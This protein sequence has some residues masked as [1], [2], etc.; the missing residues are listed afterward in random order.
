[1]EK[2]KYRSAITVGMLACSML[3]S[4]GLLIGCGPGNVSNPPKTETVATETVATPPVRPACTHPT[5]WAWSHHTYPNGT[6]QNYRSPSP[7][8]GPLA[9]TPIAQPCPVHPDTLESHTHPVDSV[10]CTVCGAVAVSPD[11]QW[12]QP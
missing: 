7:L 8:P 5:F 2:D 10:R 4:F 12:S 11:W 1:M 6:T 9:G 3:L